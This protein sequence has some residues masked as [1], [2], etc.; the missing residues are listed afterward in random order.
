MPVLACE[1]ESRWGHQTKGESN[2]RRNKPTIKHCDPNNDHGSR[3]LCRKHIHM[4]R[5]RKEPIDPRRYIRLRIDQLTDKRAKNNDHHT[6]L[7]IDKSIA[8]L[9]IVLDLLERKA[10]L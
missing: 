3:Q 9:S 1:F 5:R 7:I 6:H 2:D 8:E 10:P 4:T